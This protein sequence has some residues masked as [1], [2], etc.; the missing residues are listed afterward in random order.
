MSVVKGGIPDNAEIENDEESDISV[1][2]RDYFWRKN[3]DPSTGKDFDPEFDSAPGT[4]RFFD[5]NIKIVTDSEMKHPFDINAY[6]LSDAEFPEIEINVIKR[7]KAINPS[8]YQHL[9]SDLGN[10]IR[11][12]LEHFTQS[13][14]FKSYSRGNR[15]YDFSISDPVESEQAKYFLNKKEIPAFVRGFA[16]ESSSME[17]L[18]KRIRKMLDDYA[19]ERNISQHEEDIIYNAWISWANRNLKKKIFSI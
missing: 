2:I 4:N 1:I 14:M 16:D 10:A 12:E 6:A 9:R 19:D 3:I 17:D 15:Y 7:D 13:G 11:H 18:K 5:V 8:L